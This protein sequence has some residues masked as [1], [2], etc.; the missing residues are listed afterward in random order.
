VAA[1]LIHGVLEDNLTFAPHGTLLAANLGLLA[2]LPPHRDSRIRA[3]WI[4]ALGILAAVCGLGLSASSAVA[5]TDAR[6]AQAALAAGQVERAMERSTAA[7]RLAPWDDLY[8]VGRADASV[9]AARGGRGIEALRDAETSYKS[10]IALNG[11]DP[12]TRHQL[13][14]LYLAHTDV[15]GSQDVTRA[16]LELQAALAQNPYYA[17]IRNDLGVAFLASGERQKAVQSFEEASQG[18]REFVDPLLNLAAL[19]LEDGNTAKA[20]HLV[21]QALERNPA[22]PRAAAMRQSLATHPGA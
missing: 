3:R 12:V 20:K 15:F 6:A 2:A 7:T 17:E 4:G 13:A 18:R 10:A 21:D 5:A 1:L 14:R 11:S 19:A 22:S 9:A 8:W 16:R